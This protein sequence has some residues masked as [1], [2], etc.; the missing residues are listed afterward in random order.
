ME[1]AV[2]QGQYK[3]KCKELEDYSRQEGLPYKAVLS[4]FDRNKARLI[5]QDNDEEEEDC[6]YPPPNPTWNHGPSAQIEQG[7]LTSRVLVS[8]TPPPR[9]MV[10][11]APG[12]AL[13][14]A[15]QQETPHHSAAVPMTPS[16]HNADV[17]PSSDGPPPKKP[18]TI[19]EFFLPSQ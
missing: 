12:T 10:H 4:W 11:V 7:S 5:Q 14:A 17:T 6:S 15:Q 2:R 16:T 9:G 3:R 8:R 18:K 19:R 1:E 13:V